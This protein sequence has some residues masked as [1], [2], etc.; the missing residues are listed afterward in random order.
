M[1]WGHR[2]SAPFR[3]PARAEVVSSAPPSVALAKSPLPVGFDW[4]DVGGV[5]YVTSDVNQHAPRSCGSSWIHGTVAALNDRIKIMRSARFPDVMISRQA[6]MNCVP[7]ADAS[8]PPGCDG[9]D[10]WMVHEYLERATVPDETCQP[11]EAQNGVCDALGRCRSCAPEG[12]PGRRPAGVVG[13]GCSGVPS[14]VGYG[15]AEYG[16]VH[17]EAAMQREILAR[18][19]IV[20]SLAADARFAFNYSEVASAHDGVY[21]D[22]APFAAADVNHDVA[23]SGWGVS[24]GG[25]PYWIAR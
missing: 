18:G 4:R 25:V 17:G 21:V 9:G 6:L 5:N 15:V 11:Y 10:A 12:L 1:S 2:S 22:D 16:A 13:P 23:V 8:A 3:P 20:C 7:G 24:G 19:P 14:Y